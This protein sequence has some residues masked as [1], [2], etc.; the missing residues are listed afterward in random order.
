MD[1]GNSEV[2]L[3][4]FSDTISKFS[5]IVR[6]ASYSMLDEAFLYIKNQS[7][8]SFQDI[9]TNIKDVLVKQVISKG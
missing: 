3:K 2:N 4:T 5:F 7:D 1:D 6:S 8:E 9:I